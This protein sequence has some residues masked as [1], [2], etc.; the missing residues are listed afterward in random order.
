MC[1]LIIPTKSEIGIISTKIL[2][3]VLSDITSKLSFNIWDNT[4]ATLEWFKII[5]NKE[6]CS[7]IVFDIIEFYP[8]TS[9]E[10]LNSALRFASK[11]PNITEDETSIINHCKKI[12]TLQRGT[13]MG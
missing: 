6:V 5:G 3:R 10:L 13:T 1:R 11:Y 12:H 4:A 2:D 7:F 8:S 9:E